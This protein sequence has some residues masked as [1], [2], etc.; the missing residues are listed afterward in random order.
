[1]RVRQARSMPESISL[2]VEAT[3]PSRIARTALPSLTGRQGI[4][5]AAG[6]GA[7]SGTA[8]GQPGLGAAPA[9]EVGQRYQA[10][11][12]WL[13]SGKHLQT[14]TGRGRRSSRS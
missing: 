12:V 13:R 10:D 11:K 6:R 14:W 8:L 4:P 9:G 7:G 1:M 5:P 2:S 3:A